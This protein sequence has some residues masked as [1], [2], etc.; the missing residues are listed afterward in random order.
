ML[1][2]TYGA[3]V[4]GVEALVVTMEVAIEGGYGFCIVGL[5]DTAVKESYERVRSAIKIYGVEFPRKDVVVNMSPADVKKE[6]AAYDLPIAIAVPS[7]LSALF[8]RR[9]LPLQ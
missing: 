6:G 1:T 5:P 4:S 9:T 8:F 3:A 7:V 2:K